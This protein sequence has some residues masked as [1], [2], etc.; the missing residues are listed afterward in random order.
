MQASQAVLFLRGPRTFGIKLNMQLLYKTVG[1]Y[2]YAII[3][4]YEWLTY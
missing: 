1:Y 4:L 2:C 3:Q